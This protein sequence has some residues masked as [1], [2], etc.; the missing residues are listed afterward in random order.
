MYVLFELAC[1]RH[2]SILR[3][4]LQRMYRR[5]QDGLPMSVL[6]VPQHFVLT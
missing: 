2:V 5:L 4:V 6:I 1:S 3:R